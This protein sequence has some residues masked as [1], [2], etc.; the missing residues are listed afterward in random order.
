[1]YS[2]Y[3]MSFSSFALGQRV[4]YLQSEINL[5]QSEIAAI[6]S[7]AGPTGP[8]GPTGPQGDIGSTGPQGD[9]GATGATGPQGDI[10]PQGDTG[11]TGATGPQGDTGATGPQ[12]DTGATGPQGDT[13]ATGPQCDTGATGPQG[14]TGATGPQGDTGATGPQGDTGATGP[15]GDTGP[16]GPQG[17]TGPTGP[18]GD[19]G[20]TGPQGDTGPTGPQGDTGPTGPQGDTG[21][22]GAT[23]PQGDT[24]STGATGPQGDPANA[25]LWATFPA[26]QTVDMSGNNLTNFTDINTTF[27]NPDTTTNFISLKMSDEH[28]SV[29]SLL[30]LTDN[31]G[32]SATETILKATTMSIKDGVGNIIVLD[33]VS[34]DIYIQDP[35]GNASGISPTYNTIGDAS[36]NVITTTPYGITLEKTT[37]SVA[38]QIIFND[39][40]TGYNNNIQYNQ[41]NMNGLDSVYTAQSN[42]VFLQNGDNTRQIVMDLAGNQIYCADENGFGSYLKTTENNMYDAS[43]NTIKTKPTQI[44]MADVDS[45][46]LSEW[47]TKTFTIGNVILKAQDKPDPATDGM[48]N[49]DGKELTIYNANEAVWKLI[50]FV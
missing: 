26:T 9:I 21:S 5:L 41:I 12:G 6:I 27:T 47:N 4:S 31:I 14:D 36:G 38:S 42:A 23:G 17:D 39:A 18:Q 45:N 11:S 8:R 22:T 46:V 24:G 44:V 25:S 3:I 30:S 28:G 48:I 15:Q 10:G 34:H 40:T 1:M 16:T 49:W 33:N 37:P 50:P 13:G 43:N 20:P 2:N 19:T 7:L 29:V 35:S 32:G